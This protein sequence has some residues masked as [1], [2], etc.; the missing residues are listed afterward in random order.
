MHRISGD[1]DLHIL[2]PD[3]LK[4]VPC[5]L[6]RLKKVTE[7]ARCC[8]NEISSCVLSLTLDAHHELQTRT[9]LHRN[10]AAEAEARERGSLKG[11]FAYF[12][13]HLVKMTKTHLA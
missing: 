1:Q 2:C 3:I 12:I 8:R 10:S 6:L 9:N 5:R 7:E 13:Y 4:D 11:K